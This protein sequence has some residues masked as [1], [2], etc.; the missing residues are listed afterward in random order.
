MHLRRM[1]RGVVVGN[2]R[3]VEG[4]VF[5]VSIRGEIISILASSGI[6]DWKRKSREE[7]LAKWQEQNN[8]NNEASTPR[9][10]QGRGSKRGCMT[11]KGGPENPSCKFR[12]VRQRTWGMWVAEIHEPNNGRQLWLGTFETA[13]AAALAYDKAAKTMYKD[14]ARLNFPESSATH[15]VSLRE[16]PEASTQ[17][18]SDSMLER[19]LPTVC[20][21]VEAAAVEASTVR[22][23]LHG[24]RGMNNENSVVDVVS[25]DVNK[26]EGLDLSDLNTLAPSEYNDGEFQNLFE[27]TTQA[28]FNYNKEDSQDYS[29]NEMLD[30][31]ELLALLN[32]DSVNENCGSM[33]NLSDYDSG[34]SGCK[35]H[36]TES[37]DF[38]QQLQNKDAELL[39]KL[40]RMEQAQPSVDY[41]KYFAK[42]DKKDDF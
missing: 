39:G 32:S 8:T 3:L 2:C 19:V 29:V 31:D 17:L 9:K 14:R 34:Q 24:D 5:G 21:N 28:P 18:N 26:E 22:S 38:S 42:K 25:N 10:I 35:E 11:G 27:A 36:G 6:V 40:H 4:S 30:I 15:Q 13:K 7:T 12:G 41:S 20:A 37:F 16:M 23:D 33:Q 1:R